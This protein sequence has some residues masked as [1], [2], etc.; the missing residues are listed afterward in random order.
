MMKQNKLKQFLPSLLLM[1]FLVVMFVFQLWLPNKKINDLEWR[2]KAS[3]EEIRELSHKILSFPV[4]NHH[5]AFI[6]LLGVGNKDSIPYLISA[7]KWQE[8]TEK[9]G[10]MSCTKSC[11][12][13]ALKKLSDHNA[14]INYSDWQ[15]WWD[16][17]GN[18]KNP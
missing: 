14:G 8:D 2:E 12:L 5:D 13:E 4:G 9:E 6:L 17:Q 16:S 7:L 11:C 18:K 3:I 15:K 1:G 10:L